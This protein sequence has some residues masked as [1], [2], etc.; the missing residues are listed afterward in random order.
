MSTTRS[1]IAALFVVCSACV[2][3]R[4]LGETADEERAE[5][6]QLACEDEQGE[7]APPQPESWHTEPSK[8]APCTPVVSLT[9]PEKTAWCGWYEM[10]Y[11]RDGGAAPATSWVDDGA[12]LGGESHMA[13]GIPGDIPFCNQHISVEHCVANLSLDDCAVPLVAVERCVRGL[14]EE[15]NDEAG[16]EMC[17]DLLGLDGCERTIVQQ[18]D[19]PTSGCAT[20][21]E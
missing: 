12:V 14:A 2:I 7:P 17:R 18:G 3:D 16:F 9:T 8:I 13:G 19:G 10:N 4:Q 21:V 1:V 20:P 6:L 11:D 15:L 5:A